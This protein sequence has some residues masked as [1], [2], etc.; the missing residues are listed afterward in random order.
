MVLEYTFFFF[1]YF[2]PYYSLLIY[3]HHCIKYL[4]IQVSNTWHK[5]RIQYKHK[6]LSL[7]IIIIQL[8]LIALGYYRGFLH[9]LSLVLC[10]RAPLLP[11]WPL[12]LDSWCWSAR[13][14]SSGPSIRFF[15]WHHSQPSAG[16]RCRGFR[17]MIGPLPRFQADDRTL[18]WKAE[19]TIWMPQ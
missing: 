12:N 2:A 17:L 6:L 8:L 7:I 5:Y 1:N 9:C 14:S 18:V 13:S 4:I 10:F 19:P 11:R 15:C 16:D 3:T